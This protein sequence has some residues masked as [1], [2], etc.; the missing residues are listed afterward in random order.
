MYNAVMKISTMASAGQRILTANDIKITSP[1]SNLQLKCISIYAN[2]DEIVTCE[3]SY[4]VDHD[5]MEEIMRVLQINRGF[6]ES[7]LQNSNDGSVTLTIRSPLVIQSEE[8]F[9]MKA[10]VKRMEP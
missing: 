1:F 10:L 9:P 7:S 8:K 5:N 2:M 3:M 6:M 4:Y